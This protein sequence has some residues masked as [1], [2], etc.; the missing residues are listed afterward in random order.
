MRMEQAA[1]LNG[2]RYA[3]F[4]QLNREQAQKLHED[5]RLYDVGD[6]IL[7]VLFVMGL[8]IS[9]IKQIFFRQ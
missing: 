1:S 4:H 6:I 3:T 2:N 8:K 7:K 9:G 5:D